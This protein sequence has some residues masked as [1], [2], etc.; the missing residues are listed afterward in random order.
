MLNLMFN[1]LVMMVGVGG[2][3][4]LKL[5]VNQKFFFWVFGLKSGDA[6][7]LIRRGGAIG[8]L[9]GGKCKYC[10]LGFSKI[11][12]YDEIDLILYR[13]LSFLCRYFL[14]PW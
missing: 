4:G 12:L 3:S 2:G 10:Y 11:E 6:S 13:F 1:A 5:G 14:Y 8:C 9:V 7:I